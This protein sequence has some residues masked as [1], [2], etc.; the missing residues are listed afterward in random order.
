MKIYYKIL[1]ILLTL[2]SCSN[3]DD[4]SDSNLN[5]IIIG[6]WKIYKQFESNVEIQVDPCDIYWIVDYGANKTVSSFNSDPDNYPTNCDI[7]LSE[8]GWNWVNRG[9]GNYEIRY[10]E[11][12]GTL[13]YFYKEGER[14]VS[15]FPDGVTKIIYDPFN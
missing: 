8:F 15:E 3:S 13:Y 5:D 6:K 14:L 12:E 7:R 2:S 1:I 11:E 4:S 10:M 9:N